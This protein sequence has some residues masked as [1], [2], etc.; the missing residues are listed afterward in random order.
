[1]TTD[2]TEK[3][4][5]NDIIAHLVSTGY[6]Q[7]G[8]HNYN[9]ASCLDPELTL[10]FIQDTQEREWKKFQRVYGE[11]SE[12]KF[13]YR[14]MNE[15]D[16][17][18]TINVLRNGLK[19]VG[20]HFELFYPKPNNKKNPDLFEKFERNI[21][22]ALDE[23][24]YN[25]PE[26]GRSQSGQKEDGKRLDLVIFIN[27]L[28]IITI[29]L[30]DTFSQGVEKAIKQYKEDRDPREPIFQRCF[31]HFAMSDEKI[32]MATKLE[33]W[34]T[35]F[36]PFNKGLENP[37]VKNDYKTSYLYND[38]L[39]INKLSKLIANFIYM[40]KDE[41]TRELKP[42]FPRYHQLDCVNKLLADTKP[43]K[44]YLIEH[45]NGSGKTKTIAWLSHGLINK[46][47]SLDN[48]VYDMVIVV[49]DRRVI[50]KQLQN[51][52]QGI[53][54]VKGI[55]EKIEK[56]SEQ[57]K[58]ALMT[59]SNIVVTTLQKFPYILEEVKDLPERNYAVIID[60]AHSSQTG[61][62]A[63]KMKQVLSTN[64]LEEAEALD[65]EDMDEVDEEIL[66]EIESYRNLKNISFFA[67]T[68]TPKSKTLEMFGMPNEY[69]HYH[70]FHTYTMK[71]AIGE[72]FIL[73][74]LKNYLTYPT[75]FKLVK[76][77]QDDPEYDEKK[78][79]RLL[80]NFVEKHPVAIARKTDIML[81]HFMNST[82][83]KIN[84]KAK[85]MVV[86]RSR[87]HAVLYKKAFDRL[88]REN[89]Y[90]I[91]TLV[92]FTDV[93]RHDEQEYTENSMNDLPSKK[94]IRNAFEEDQY[95][96]L[97]VANKFQTGFDQP[98]L[99]TMYVDKMLNGITAVQTLCRVNRI[100]PNKNDT[101]ILDF[102]NKT[103]VIQ[104]AFQPY[105]EA[106][107]LEEATDP[108]KLYELEEKLL[109]YQ[110]FD[111]SDIETFVKA[112]KKGEPQP[113]LHNIL[114]P[115]VNEFRQKTKKEQVE[116]KKTLRRYQNIYSFLSQLIPFS[117]I[118]L[119]KMYMFNKFLNK[120]LPTI[121]NPLPFSVLQDV[122]IDSYKIVKKGK[123]EIK[124]E[125]EGELKPI[126]AGVGE[127]APDINTKLSKIIKDLND[128]FGTDFTDD[129]KV[130]LGRVKDNLLE[131]KELLNKMEHNSKENVKAVFDKYFNQEINKL[132]NG[133]MNFYKRIVDNEKLK[134]KVKS[135]LFDLLYFEFNKYKKK[136]EI[137]KREN[138][139]KVT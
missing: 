48:R 1:M 139:P 135:A 90:P 112:W 15:I 65:T 38:I 7:R 109:D 5:Q 10:K 22:S 2:T 69:G 33:G 124:I 89:N 58:E 12:Q 111:K 114:S 40:E 94:E 41:D 54:K 18:G 53:E 63:R 47:N 35:R 25:L 99:H 110:V 96:I 78:A 28:P 74:V 27:G 29:E 14:L 102:A 121:N 87:L 57:L 101:L 103:E 20:C 51:Q 73:D 72:G 134:K 26:R 97:I 92:A 131:N 118:D 71:Q 125:S 108:H 31:V 82:I 107:F 55:V 39:Q 126:S 100:H 21:F 86:T 45:S 32:Y 17:K 119:E 81:N 66:K 34:K 61:T 95:K 83:H 37:E 44:N 67:F 68:A 120:K 105:Y 127:Y 3:A 62:M 52:V 80:R 59:G 79:K 91:K 9:K 115:V 6:R 19:D 77:I 56:H 137:N 116:F 30:K 42:I 16:K 117:D 60:E 98:L 129:D 76:K 113:K 70:P 23:L 93:V 104:K 24:E 64:S 11:Q 138:W 75:Y 8:N 128:A 130:F 50:D 36:L 133:N 4:F 85:A 122:D 123:K 132:L 88:I 106:T 43:G 136:K 13:F 46:F 49:S 84:G